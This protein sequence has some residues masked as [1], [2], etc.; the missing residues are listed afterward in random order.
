MF[1][2]KL[3]QIYEITS[4]QQAN[5]SLKYVDHK[6]CS[7]FSEM[8]LSFIVIL[9]VT[10]HTLYDVQMPNKACARNDKS[11]LTFLAY[12]V[13]GGEREMIFD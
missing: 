9:N 4:Y 6:E 3:A 11:H 10:I 13:R 12:R 1:I 5:W 7:S 8:I 2:L